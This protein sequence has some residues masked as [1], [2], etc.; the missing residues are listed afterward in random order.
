M[1]V[2]LS[3]SVEEN[4]PTSAPADWFSATLL[5]LSARSVGAE[6]TV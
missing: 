6:G 5:G 4:E 2:E 3:A 1:N